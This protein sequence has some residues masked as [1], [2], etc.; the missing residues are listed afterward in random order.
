MKGT[1]LALF[2]IYTLPVFAQTSFKSQLTHANVYY[3]YGAE[4]NHTAK[5][6]LQ[7]GTQE[8]SIENISNVLDPNTVQISVPE[9]VV[10]LSYRFNTKATDADTRA[11]PAVKIMEDS[12]KLLQR[13]INVATNDA[14][15]ANELLDKTSKL[16]ETYSGG[17]N[18]NLTAVELIKLLEF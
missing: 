6:A 11:N 7:N 14:A 3:G 5:V 10:L 17:D 1:V 8:I 12:I 15:I 18:K 9:N 4:L 13:L 16:I 2:F